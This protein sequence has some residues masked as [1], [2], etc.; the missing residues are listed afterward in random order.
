VQAL[1]NAYE[2]VVPQ[3]NGF[4][5]SGA[6]EQLIAQ[7]QKEGSREILGE[8][9]SRCEP[10]TFS[11]IRSKRTMIYEPE[12]EL[13]STINYKLVRSISHYDPG[14]GTA[15]T[16]ISKLASN[17]MC[18]S[19]SLH[20]KLSL[21]YEPLDEVLAANLPDERANSPV[22]V[23]DLHRQIRGVRSACSLESERQAQRWLIES[24]IDAHFEM[25]RHEVCD[26][27]MRVFGLTHRRSRQL[28]DLTLLEVRRALWQETTHAPVSLGGLRGTKQMPLA[29][30]F[31]FLSPPEFSKFV[32]LMRDLA[33][34][35][36]FLVRPANAPAIKRGEWPAVREN[37]QCVL[38]G[39]PEATA[40]F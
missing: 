31:N 17:M 2:T 13:M 36:I 14:K 9:V 22:Y 10:L 6:V 30:Y 28:Y 23:D 35:L 24:F 37:L 34:S 33:P 12:N 5:D 19:V 15:F 38:D 29:R 4:F 25:R 7:Y 8:I 40:L 1:E 27:A 32:R 3:S 26:A 16:F 39:I 18:T 20:K 21:R 11:L